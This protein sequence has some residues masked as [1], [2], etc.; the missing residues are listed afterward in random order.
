MDNLIKQ[1]ERKLCAVSGI[2]H[3]LLLSES[4]G[5]TL[6]QTGTLQ[7]ADWYD[8]V[9]TERIEKINPV[10]DK[11]N[12]LRVNMF[13]GKDEYISWEWQPLKTMTEK[14]T[15]EVE[16]ITAETYSILINDNVMTEQE[17]REKYDYSESNMMLKED[18]ELRKI[19]DSVNENVE[20]D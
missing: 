20:T 18:S 13:L 14:E 5:G 2:P 10:L 4:P 19:L 16:K 6:S 11:L 17:V 15:A 12:N 3:T 9:E 7:Q 1:P 8:K